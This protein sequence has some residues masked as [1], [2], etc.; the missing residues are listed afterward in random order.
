MPVLGTAGPTPGPAATAG[1]GRSSRCPAQVTAPTCSR[2]RR[3]AAAHLS[4]A[5]ELRGAGDV[6]VVEPQ[7]LPLRHLL[8]R[9][10]VNL[11]GRR[12]GGVVRQVST[13]VLGSPAGSTAPSSPAPHVPHEG[14]STRCT[15]LGG[16]ARPSGSFVLPPTSLASEWPTDKV[17]RQHWPHVNSSYQGR[18]DPG[19]HA[20]LCPG[21]GPAGR[22]P[23]WRCAPARAPPHTLHTP[24]TAVGSPREAPRQLPGGTGRAPAPPS[25][26]RTAG[27]TAARAAAGRRA[28]WAGAASQGRC[29]PVCCMCSTAGC[30]S[31]SPAPLACW[32]S[33]PPCHAGCCRAAGS[34][35]HGLRAWVR[36]AVQMSLTWGYLNSAMPRSYTLHSGPRDGGGWPERAAPCWPPA[37]F[38]HPAGRCVRLKECSLKAGGSHS[39]SPGALAVL[40]ALV[41]CAP[42]GAS[43]HLKASSKNLF[44]SM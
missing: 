39:G 40:L 25:C 37:C 33:T 1:S 6:D 22:P 20:S 38:P 34:W 26:R 15:A 5:K 7:P 4:D 8:H 9:L 43:A 28:G 32:H 29:A 17:P 10:V 16:A 11:Q 27:Q 2:H 31:R 24:G 19:W 23:A 21:A 13:T 30:G 36:Y 41:G 44:S 14:L 12:S 35:S 42:P 18:G 3:A